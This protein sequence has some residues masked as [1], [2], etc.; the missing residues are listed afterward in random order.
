VNRV[1]HENSPQG[2]SHV[3]HCT[4]AGDGNARVISYR[5]RARDFLVSS[6]LALGL[7]EE[8]VDRGGQRPFRIRAPAR[9]LIGDTPIVDLLLTPSLLRNLAD[10]QGKELAIAITTT[11]TFVLAKYHSETVPQTFTRIR[12]NIA[13]LVK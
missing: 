12:H 7:S 1:T 5:S 2:T 9:L 4:P 8:V 13:F 10:T 6:A 3:A 11:T